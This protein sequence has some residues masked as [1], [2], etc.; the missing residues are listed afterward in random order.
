MNNK[1]G[2]AMCQNRFLI[3]YYLAFSEQ[4]KNKTLIIRKHFKIIIKKKAY[5]QIDWK[6]RIEKKT[7]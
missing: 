4:Y 2:A 6:N 1:A 7:N 3:H 5:I